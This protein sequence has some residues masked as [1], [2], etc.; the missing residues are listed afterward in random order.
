MLQKTLLVLLIRSSIPSLQHIPPICQQLF[1]KLE[2]LLCSL[3]FQHP[4]PVIPKD[5]SK[6]DAPVEFLLLFKSI[7]SILT[8]PNFRDPTLTQ[9]NRIIPNTV[10]LLA[11][12]DT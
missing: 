5:N 9:V 8:L 4:I 12:S 1:L 6:R 11:A 7:D 3:R 10:P 2:T